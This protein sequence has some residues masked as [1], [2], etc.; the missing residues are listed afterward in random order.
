MGSARLDLP[1]GVLALR[2][3][4]TTKRFLLSTIP[5]ERLDRPRA[6]QVLFFPHL[7]DGAGFLTEFHLLNLGA[8]R[9]AT[10]LQFFDQKGVSLPLVRRD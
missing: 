6:P 2:S 9:T 4:Q 1:V 3:L 7:A 8:A 5:V 10:S